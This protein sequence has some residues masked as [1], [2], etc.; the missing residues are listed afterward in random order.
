VEWIEQKVGVHC[1]QNNKLYVFP[2]RVAGKEILVKDK[3]LIAKRLHPMFLQQYSLGENDGVIFS[4]LGRGTIE[5][6]PL[7]EGREELYKLI[8]ELYVLFLASYYL[9]AQMKGRSRDEVR[10]EMKTLIE[11]YY[12]TQPAVSATPVTIEEQSLQPRQEK[13]EETKET[14]SAVVTPKV[15][16]G[17]KPTLV[18]EEKAEEEF[19]TLE[20][21]RKLPYEE[22]RKI[23][24]WEPPVSDFPA[25]VAIVKYKIASSITRDEK[26][27]EKLDYCLFWFMEAYRKCKGPE[28]VKKV[29]S[30]Y[31]QYV[32]QITQT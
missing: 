28:E 11:G 16:E 18:L 13:I 23:R 8:S 21:I 4:Y 14:A 24:E 3:V 2:T 20:E 29:L 12:F 7:R 1:V 26:I 30:D 5:F 10:G 31:Y 22:V 27:R 9:Y 32:Q 15:S 17:T 6:R 25:R 19:P